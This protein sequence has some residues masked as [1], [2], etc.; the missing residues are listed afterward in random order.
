[1]G[2]TGDRRILGA[3]LRRRWR[4]TNP[5]ADDVTDR[6]LLEVPA[7]PASLALVRLQV[8]GIAALNGDLV[9]DVEDLQLAADELCLTLM[10]DGETAARLAVEVEWDQEQLTV[11]CRLFG[12]DAQRRGSELD[13]FLPGIVDQILD[14]LVDEHGAEV[15]GDHRVL[16]IR[17]RRAAG[18]RGG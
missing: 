3:V 16:W 2:S 9:T 7:R 14:A 6:I 18:P 13:E 17:R 10:P 4:R 5:E 12:G 8:G 1:M 11:R 15:E